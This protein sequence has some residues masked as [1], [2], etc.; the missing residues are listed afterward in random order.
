MKARVDQLIEKSE[1]PIISDW[2]RG[3]LESV[4]QQ[5]ERGRRE[6]SARQCEIIERVEK[7]FVGLQADSDWESQWDEEKAWEWKT[8]VSYYEE[9][10]ERYYSRILDWAKENPGK[11]PPAVF[12]RKLVENKYAQKI[13]KALR[14][15]PKY[16]AGASVMLRSGARAPLGYFLYQEMMNELLFVVTPTDKAIHAAKGCRIYSIL[17]ST[18]A[19][20]FEIEERF[21]KKWRKTKKVEDDIPF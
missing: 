19:K 1:N 13:I 9:G 6:L 8:A 15:E 5:L 12:Y 16:A 11:V 10:T 7:K 2:E 4:H 20:T 14:D 18:S 3:F 21:I 17:S